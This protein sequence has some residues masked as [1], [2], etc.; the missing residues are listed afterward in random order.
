MRSIRGEEWSLCPSCWG[1]W[2]PQMQNTAGLPP[3]A[4][5]EG[6]R[7]G[8]QLASV[9]AGDPSSLGASTRWHGHPRASL[10]SGIMGFT[11]LKWSQRGPPAVCVPAPY[12]HLPQEIW[13]KCSFEQCSA[14]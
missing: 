7:H 8:K 9:P 1:A 12:L 2:V 4:W 11:T 14:I 3:G 5:G 10:S 13:D 6:R